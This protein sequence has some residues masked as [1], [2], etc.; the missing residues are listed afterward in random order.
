MID[1]FGNSITPPEQPKKA[2]NQCIA[3]YGKGPE[4]QTCKGCVHLRYPIQRNPKARFWK[5]DLR[6]LTHGRA[7]D[8]K[9]SYPACG[10]YEPRTEEYHGG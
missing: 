5:C 7:T 6:R 9:V 4:G 3:L 1:W 10:R 2:D 8:H